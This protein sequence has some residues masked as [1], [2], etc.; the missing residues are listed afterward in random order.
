MLKMASHFIPRALAVLTLATLAASSARADI[1]VFHDLTAEI[2]FDQLPNTPGGPLLDN[3]SLLRIPTKKIA[4]SELKTIT[5]SPSDAGRSI[6]RQVIV[7]SQ[8]KG[9]GYRQ[10]HFV[11]VAGDGS[12]GAKFA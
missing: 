5:T 12:A 1:F 3:V 4:H 11:S 2:S 7:M 8:E 9:W 6:V 10:H